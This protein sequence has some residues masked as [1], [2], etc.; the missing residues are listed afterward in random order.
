MKF[1]NFRRR[2]T[3]HSEVE[4][5]RDY[6]RLTDLND[7]AQDALEVMIRTDSRDP[8]YQQV[9][10]LYEEAER[11]YER[12]NEAYENARIAYD[13][14]PR[15]GIR[16][17][18]VYFSQKA[19]DRGY[20]RAVELHE[21]AD[22]ALEMLNDAKPGNPGYGHICNHCKKA[23]RVSQRDTLAHNGALL[24]YHHE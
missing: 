5:W 13:S 15:F 1:F 6:H 24:F 14:A 7:R 3:Y 21:K 17:P 23:E 19:A 4:A 16:L 9:C 11:T 8:R 18:R 20:R 12:E 10:A 2:R 22:R